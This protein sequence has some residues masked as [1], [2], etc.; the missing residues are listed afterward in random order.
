MRNCYLIAETLSIDEFFDKNIEADIDLWGNTIFENLKISS[1]SNLRG[2][3]NQK[4]QSL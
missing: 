3:I 4:L 2:I 1:D